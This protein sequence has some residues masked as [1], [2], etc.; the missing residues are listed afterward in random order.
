M[1]HLS[2]YR[3]SFCIYEDTRPSLRVCKRRLRLFFLCMG[4]FIVNLLFLTA[5]AFRKGL[6]VKL[7]RVVFGPLDTAVTLGGGMN[8]GRGADPTTNG[9]ARLP[10]DVAGAVTFMA[11]NDWGY[12]SAVCVGLDALDTRLLDATPFTERDLPT[13][14]LTNVDN[15]GLLK[16]TESSDDV[17]AKEPRGE[18]FPSSMIPTTLFVGSDVALDALETLEALE[19]LDAVDTMEDR[20]TSEY[21]D[22]GCTVPVSI[23]MRL[24]EGSPR[25]SLL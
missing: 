7:R 12:V 13:V 1:R 4:L 16:G 17:D 6:R 21:E 25:L 2:L 24:P 9:G 20:R 10:T 23:F 19:T 15:T 18:L 22:R 8:A 14:F 11:R 5:G 3:L